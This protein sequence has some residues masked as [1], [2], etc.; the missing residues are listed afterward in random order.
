MSTATPR[1][2]ERIADLFIEA[3]N[4]RSMYFAALDYWNQMSEHARTLEIELSAKT[5]EC[6][7]LECALQTS[8]AEMITLLPRLTPMYRANI[9]ACI[10][11]ASAALVQP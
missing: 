6:E 8:L 5:A 11:K 7:R 10:N 4:F 3:G 2:D 1:T 9:Q